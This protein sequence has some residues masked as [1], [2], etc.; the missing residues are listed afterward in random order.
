MIGGTLTNSFRVRGT[1]Q[2]WSHLVSSYWAILEGGKEGK[3]EGGREREG[4][5]ER[6]RRVV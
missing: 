6:G 1:V 2:G 5:I 4:G 3:R